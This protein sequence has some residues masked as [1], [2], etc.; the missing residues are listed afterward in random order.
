MDGRWLQSPPAPWRHPCNIMWFFVCRATTANCSVV[1]LSWSEWLLLVL[2]DRV[3]G[4]CKF[5]RLP[6]MKQPDFFSLWLMLCVRRQQT[7]L[8]YYWG[9]RM[10]EVCPTFQ[11]LKFSARSDKCICCHI[12]GSTYCP[13]RPW[14]AV[15]G[16]HQMQNTYSFAHW[17][18]SWIT[19]YE[20]CEADALHTPVDEK[21]DWQEVNMSECEG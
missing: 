12:R 4:A 7:Q 18:F 11:L 21:I 17:C 6:A 1:W 20:K 14:H 13:L 8:I 10:Q 3:P 16:M 15:T 9:S 2:E 5:L 19:L